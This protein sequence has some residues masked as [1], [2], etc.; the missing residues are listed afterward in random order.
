[1][2]MKASQLDIIREKLI[3]S[4][5]QLRSYKVSLGSQLEQSVGLQKALDNAQQ[6]VSQLNPVTPIKVRQPI[7]GR[8]RSVHIF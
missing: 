7:S 3:A 6:L 5:E 2:F 8:P 1:M 4:S